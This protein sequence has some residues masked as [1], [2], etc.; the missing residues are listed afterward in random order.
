M[1]G[2]LAQMVG[3]VEGRE[4][5]ENILKGIRQYGLDRIRKL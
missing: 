3:V 2:G 1:V 5:V 4:E